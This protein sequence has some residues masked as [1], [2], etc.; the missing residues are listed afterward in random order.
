MASEV[1]TREAYPE[2]P[3]AAMRFGE[4]ENHSFSSFSFGFGSGAG[5]IGGGGTNG[6]A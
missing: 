5:I 3:A 1:A 6:G 4:P 2:T